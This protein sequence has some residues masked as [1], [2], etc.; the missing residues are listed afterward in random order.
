MTNKFKPFGG[1][2]TIT[3]EIERH[4]KRFEMLLKGKRDKRWHQIFI[5][6]EG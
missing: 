1:E 4:M 5:E 2:F 6:R 3:N